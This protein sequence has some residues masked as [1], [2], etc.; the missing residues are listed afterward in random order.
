MMGQKAVEPRRYHRLA[1]GLMV[2]EHHLVRRLAEAVDLELVRGLVR[3]HHRHAG[4]PSV[5]PVGL[6]ERWRSGELLNL[7]SERGW[8]EAAGSSL[9]WG[10][11][12]GDERDE[13]LLARIVSWCERAS[14]R[15]RSGTSI[16][17]W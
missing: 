4:Q 8:R 1:L 9:A 17:P 12:L 2:P 10:W 7:T 14:S 11:L 13:L 3:R 16:P 6:L 15:A 5:D